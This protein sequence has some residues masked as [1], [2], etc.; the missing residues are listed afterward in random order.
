[1]PKYQPLSQKDLQAKIKELQDRITQMDRR[2]QTLAD[3]KRWMERHKLTPTDI[4][5][6]YRQM[7]PQRA[8]KAVKSK[9]PLQPANGKMHPDVA[10]MRGEP[11]FEVKGDPEF[12]RAIREKRE[13]LGLSL[14]EMSRQVPG[15]SGAS[16]SGWERGRYIPTEP[17][18]VKYLTHLKLPLTLGA[19]ATAAMEARRYNH[20][21]DG[22]QAE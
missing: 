1:M 5:W 13:E 9:K 3:L 12:Q 16:I 10:K 20:P 22:A 14:E 15:I 6:M 19:G 8:A 7:A 11:P 21:R 18:R 4:L 2:E 17:L